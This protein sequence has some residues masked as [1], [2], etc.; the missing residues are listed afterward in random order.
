[1]IEFF[2]YEL[3]IY[4]FYF[5]LVKTKRLINYYKQLYNCQRSSDNSELRITN[6]EFN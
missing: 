6:F 4:S 1:M 5:L 3:N 2:I